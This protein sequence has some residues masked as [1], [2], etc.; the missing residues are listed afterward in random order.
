MLLLQLTDAKK[1]IVDL[2]G[3]FDVVWGLLLRAVGGRC[4]ACAGGIGC[5]VGSGGWG[6]G[7]REGSRNV[8]RSWIG[9]SGDGL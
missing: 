2:L 8:R 4:C 7:L 6:D 9:L 5:A 3:S 1:L